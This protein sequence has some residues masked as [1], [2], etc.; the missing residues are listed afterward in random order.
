MQKQATNSIC[1]TRWI[2]GKVKEQSTQK[3]I[4]TNASTDVS[5]LKKIRGRGTRNG[6]RAEDVEKDDGRA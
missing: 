4:F 3:M 6:S 2:L 5:K 1:R